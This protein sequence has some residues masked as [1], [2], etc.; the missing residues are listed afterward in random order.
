MDHIIDIEDLSFTY[1]KGT[2][3]ERLA[4]KNVNITANTANLKNAML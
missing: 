2:P 1:M 4:L 3:Y